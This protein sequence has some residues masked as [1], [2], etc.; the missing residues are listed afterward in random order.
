VWDITAL[1]RPLQWGYLL[2]GTDYGFSWYWSLRMILLIMVSFEM[3]RILSKKDKWLSIA[4]GIW[5]ALMP[6]FMWWL[7]TSVLD[8]YIFGM[9]T[10]VLFYQYMQNLKSSIWKKILIAIG[11]FITLPG[12]VFAFYPAIQISI[13]FIMAAFFIVEL[14]K[15]WK[16]LGKADY[17]IMGVTLIL[18]AL[19]VVRYFIISWDDIVLMMNTVYPGK[20]RSSGIINAI[21]T[22][23]CSWLT[24]F[25]PYNDSVL[26]NPCE[27]SFAIFPLSALAIYCIYRL[28]DLNKKDYKKILNKD[29]ALFIALVLIF[30]FYIVYAT[31]GFPK[32]LKTITLLSFVSAGRIKI[33]IGML[34]IMI[35]I[36][37]MKKISESDKKIVNI[38]QGIV[39]S[40]I[41]GILSIVIIKDSSYAGKFGI[42]KMSVVFAIE[43]LM[44]YLLLRARKKEFCVVIAVIAIVAGAYVNP[45]CLGSKAVTQTEI[46]NEIKKID[47]EN[48]G[49]LWLAGSSITGQYLIANGINTLNGVNRYPNYK[50]IDIVDENK[51]FEQI[52]NRYAH[53][54]VELGDEINFSLTSPDSYIVTLTYDKLKELGVTY[55]FTTQN[56]KDNEKKFNLKEVYVNDEKSQYI[57]E[58]N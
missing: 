44:T 53:I 45:I 57:Y 56:E 8:C 24:I 1:S 49:M 16:E 18:C 41:I 36:M 23:A 17:I 54:S 20:T 13:G 55:F 31:V 4:G 48:E 38:P 14:C 27:T 10:V 50:W 35:S 12:F 52:W 42:I 5:L 43:F 32:I 30:I 46:A 28:K 22:L 47:S 51:E 19:Q 15:R 33:V 7:S 3:A 25:A 58:I 21:E 9:A 2:F 39:I 11:I 6:A 26:N 34:G 40:A 29:N 37:A